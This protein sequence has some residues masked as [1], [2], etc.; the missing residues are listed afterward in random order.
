[1]SNQAQH[2][3]TCNPILQEAKV[4]GLLSLG[5]VWVIQ[6]IPQQSRILSKT[7]FQTKKQNKTKQKQTNKQTNK[8]K[9]GRCLSG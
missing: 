9:A 7:L 5:P 2:S 8:T 3:A 6:R 1:M 4:Q